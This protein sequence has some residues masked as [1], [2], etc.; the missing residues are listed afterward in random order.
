MDDVA[1]RVLWA[2]G[3]GELTGVKPGEWV[4]H[5]YELL[6]EHPLNGDGA[7]DGRRSFPRDR[8]VPLT[9]TSSG[10]SF[11]SEARRQ[12]DD[13]LLG[14]CLSVFEN[15]QGGRVAVST[16]APWE[17]LG[18]AAKRRQLLNVAA[19]LT[20]GQTPI[21]IDENV[22][23]VPFVR[24][25]K[26]GQKVAAVLLNSSFD[27]TGPLKVRFRSLGKPLHL[28]GRK[29]LAALP[30]ARGREETVVHVPSIPPWRTTVLVTGD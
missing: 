25:N 4:D 17:Q 24:R 26:S 22:R 21:R 5:C 29:G 6:T 18:R 11:P 1:L 12:N 20:A 13:G 27:E 8:A 23:V 9:A 10:V 15:K 30:S 2:R 16:Y 7:G 3:L 14:P 28:V 19:W